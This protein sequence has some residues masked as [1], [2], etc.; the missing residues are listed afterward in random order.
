MA[1]N[2]LLTISALTGT[3]SMSIRTFFSQIYTKNVFF[4]VENV[5]FALEGVFIKWECYITNKI[6]LFQG[7]EQKS[8]QELCT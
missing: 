4:D 7:F 6:C 8:G 5:L 3:L 2:F 1:R